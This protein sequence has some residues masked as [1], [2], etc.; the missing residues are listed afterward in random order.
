VTGSRNA[1]NLGSKS[2]S[3]VLLVYV[4]MELG[5]SAA[6][7]LMWSVLLDFSK[8][9]LMLPLLI[10]RALVSLAYLQHQ[11]AP[12]R[13]L[14][15]QGERSRTDTRSLLAA[16]EALSGV[17]RR[18]WAVHE[19]SWLLT[20]LI[21]LLPAFG[22]AYDRPLGNAELLIAALIIIA[23]G[24]GNWATLRNPL[25]TALHP[26][27]LQV[28]HSLFELGLEPRRQ[29]SSI[30]RYVTL[31]H[32]VATAVLV[33]A[34]CAVGIKFRTERVR[35]EALG[36]QLHL[37]TVA[38]ARFGTPPE[39]GVS[40][41]ET[42]QLPAPLAASDDAEIGDTFAVFDP[43][44]EHVLAA[45]ALGDGRWAF[46]EAK[47]DEQLGLTILFCVAFVGVIMAAAA[48]NSTAIGRTVAEP[49]EE[50]EAAA[51]ELIEVGQVG[52]IKRIVPLRDDEA[53][54]LARTFNS[55]LDTLDELALAAKAVAEGDLTAEIDRP[56]DLPDAFRAMLGHLRDM[57]ERMHETTLELASAASE[58]LAATETQ[59]AAAEQ[60]AAS[61][62][63][64]AKTTS[65]LAESA[66]QITAAAAAVRDNAEQSM[67]T[68]LSSV[69]RIEE[70]DH[71]ARGIRELLELIHEIADRSD[72]LALNGSLEAVRAA[73][74]GRGFGLVAT[75]MRR[76][77]ERV[78]GAVEDIRERVGAIERSTTNTVS[79][80]HHSRNLAESTAE[81]ARAINDAIVA[82]SAR[83][84]DAA[85][86]T[87]EIAAA[88]ASFARATNQTRSTAESL[89]QHADQLS[90]ITRDFRV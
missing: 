58:I 52:R 88:I 87:R 54:A 21:S 29:R 36:D 79:A 22:V 39:S 48:S 89:R 65:S 47:P 86:G 74:A 55:M 61:I 6:V 44:S 62:E 12:V 4:L 18:L 25:E 27:R 34:G 59:G 83:T 8:P 11:L 84:R 63:Q 77:A 72:L 46:A 50:I 40:F 78:G 45:V 1:A 57:V 32:L 9:S 75:E 30:A 60:Q 69:T 85:D 56:G 14:L 53:G 38:A 42:A 43:A 73:E 70:L 35:A 33:I 64:V 28:N 13:A 31:N 17:L 51:R 20:L 5:G 16:D 26:A 82:Q 49:L 10:V 3:R 24:L 76:L 67:E 37:A 90:R 2:L 81:A 7:F 66:Q 19:V 41:V 71:E 68:A 15:R 80:T 23:N